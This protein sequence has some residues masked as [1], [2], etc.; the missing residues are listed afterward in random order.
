MDHPPETEQ[1]YTNP[2][3]YLP[4]AEASAQTTY[5]DFILLESTQEGSTQTTDEDFILLVPRREVGT[6]TTWE[7]FKFLVEIQKSGNTSM[8]TSDGPADTSEAI[9]AVWHGYNN[10]CIASF[11][12]FFCKICREEV[13]IKGKGLHDSE[14]ACIVC[15]KKFQCKTLLEVHSIE[16]K[17]YF[18]TYC[19]VCNREILYDHK[20]ENE[21][22]PF[23]SVAYA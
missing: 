7:D 3:Y 23:S 22:N 21:E 2:A 19:R 20:I 15:E 4:A 10:I 12:S 16:H 6:Q 17:N 14:Y 9:S 13:P 5:E 18:Q 8:S 1:G 11:C